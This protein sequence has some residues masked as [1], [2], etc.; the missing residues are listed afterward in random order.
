MIKKNIPH[1]GKLMAKLNNVYEQ[2]HLSAYY[3]RVMGV[4]Y[5]K[6]ARQDAKEIIEMLGK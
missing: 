5:I 4:K 2:L 1:N 3:R 6:A